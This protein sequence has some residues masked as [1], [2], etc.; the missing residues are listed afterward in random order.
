M[1]CTE[2][3]SH[4]KPAFIHRTKGA[5]TTIL[6][7]PCPECS[8]EVVRR[9][10]HMID[11][12]GRHALSDAHKI[13]VLCMSFKAVPAVKRSTCLPCDTAASA[14]AACIRLKAVQQGQHFGKPIIPNTSN[15]HCQINK[16]RSAAVSMSQQNKGQACAT[17]EAQDLC[18]R[19]SAQASGHSQL[20]L[21]MQEHDI[22][23][24]HCVVADMCGPLRHNLCTGS[25]HHVTPQALCSQ[26]CMLSPRLHVLYILRFTYRHACSA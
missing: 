6:V 17:P 5:A 9:T 20:L 11:L 16:Q 14:K 25:T 8:H 19:F 4:L 21:P 23:L 22:I 13:P 26:P 12:H 2:C 7:Q 10:W 1:H 15:M 3:G 18:N 24:Q